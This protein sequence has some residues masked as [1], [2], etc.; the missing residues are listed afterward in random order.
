MRIFAGEALEPE[1]VSL[2][3]S[4]GNSEAIQWA[5]WKL[6]GLHRKNAKIP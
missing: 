6:E 5:F 3:V 2:A 1:S 4:F